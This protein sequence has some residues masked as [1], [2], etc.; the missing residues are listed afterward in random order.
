MT[1]PLLLALRLALAAVFVVAALAKLADRDGARRSLVDFGV[2][3]RLAPAVAVALPLAELLLAAG[4][5]VS[6]TAWVAALGAAGLLGAFTLAVGV[7]LARG[8]ESD[9]HCFGRLSAEPVGPRTLARNLSLL[10][11]AGLAAVAGRDDMGTSATSWLGDL[12]T[13][14]LLGLAAVGGVALNFAFLYQL[15]KQ[16]GRLWAEVEQL[17]ASAGGRRGPAIGDPAPRFALPDLTGAEVEL[18]DLLVGGRGAVLVF[19][20]PGCSACDALLPVIARLERDPASDPRPVLISRGSAEQVRAKVA[21]H[22]VEHVLLTGDDFEL[23]KSFGV[24]GTPGAVVLD[25]SGRIAAEAVLGTQ[26]VG[27]LLA[28]G[29]LESAL[30][31]VEAG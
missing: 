1:D 22:G 26:R 28:K 30:V 21:G 16:N 10:A 29:P 31:L 12:S 15:F 20:D 23:A 11:L 3:V 17:R 18:D 24:T 9:C 14:A 25:R 19:T 6:A 7:T 8:R 27:A 2:P 4:L 13:G 5:V